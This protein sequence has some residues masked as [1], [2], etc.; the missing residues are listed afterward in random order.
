M[1]QNDLSK[2]RSMKL[3]GRRLKRKLQ[4]PQSLDGY[5]FTT[6]KLCKILIIAACIFLCT[7][8]FPSIPQ[9]TPVFCTPK[10]VCPSPLLGHRGRG[11]EA[12]TFL[13][14]ICRWQPYPDWK[15]T[16]KEQ[17]A[18][19]SHGGSWRMTDVLKYKSDFIDS[20]VLGSEEPDFFP[21]R[22]FDELKKSWA[23]VQFV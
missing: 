22:M 18:V 4:V 9:N 11:L 10:E 3:L 2:R 1:L 21:A 8:V 15:E 16:Q 19:W 5:A 20:R 14:S 13:L 7:P 23:T 12:L 6:R 17:N